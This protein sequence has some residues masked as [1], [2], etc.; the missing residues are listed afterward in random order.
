MPWD[1]IL[2]GVTG[3]VGNIITAWSN[4]KT[5]KLKNEHDEAMYSFKIQELGAKTDAAIKITE[6]K[7][8]GAVELADSEAYKASQTEGNKQSFSDSWIDKLFSVEGWLSY[9]A[10]PVAVLLAMLLGSVDVHKG[11]MRPGLTLY[12]TAVTTWLTWTAYG[13]LQQVG[14]NMTSQQALDIYNQVTSIVIYLTVSC[15]TWWFGDRRIAKFL[16]RLDDG[17]IKG[18][19]VVNKPKGQLPK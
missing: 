13:I 12:L 5:Q 18:K 1:I 15:V 11:I 7:I 4:F 3:L 2:G 14:A 9:I 16:M 19:Q 6:A 10:T 17:N 8:S